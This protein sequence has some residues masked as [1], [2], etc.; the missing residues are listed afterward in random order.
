MQ[1]ELLSMQQ[2]FEDI[3][4]MQRDAPNVGDGDMLR[5]DESNGRDSGEGAFRDGIDE[6][7]DYMQYDTNGEEMYLEDQ[8]VDYIDVYHPDT[9][10][11]L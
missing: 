8:D 7:D 9:R 11:E 10:D 2:H 4:A 5:E 3:D 1:S 6:D